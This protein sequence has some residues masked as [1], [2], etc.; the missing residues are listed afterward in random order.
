MPPSCGYRGRGAASARIARR[1][2]AETILVI[3]AMETEAVDATGHAMAFAE[4]I[5]AGILEAARPREFRAVEGK[6]SRRAGTATHNGCF[7]KQR[8][9]APAVLGDPYV[10]PIWPSNL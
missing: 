8:G 2:E 10:L 9:V 1:D 7:R 4:A 6:G 3:A 5:A